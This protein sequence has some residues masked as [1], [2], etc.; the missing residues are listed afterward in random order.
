MK[1]D[2]CLS[3]KSQITREIL[4]YLAEHSGA[5]DTLD[6]I[7]QWWLLDRK[8]KYQTAIAKEAIAE[9]VENG[10]VLE[11]KGSDLQTHYRINQRKS[12]EIQTLLKMVSE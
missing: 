8:I 1:G 11:F 3:G 9:L 2:L 5:Q 12:G 7:V 10:F 4:A 6:G